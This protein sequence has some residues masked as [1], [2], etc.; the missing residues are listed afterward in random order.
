MVVTVDVDDG[1]VSK[2]A[3][4]DYAVRVRHAGSNDITVSGI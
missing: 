1:M 3:G 4:G 2:L